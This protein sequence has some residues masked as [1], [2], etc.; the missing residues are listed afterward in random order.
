MG[1][2]L[3]GPT[4]AANEAAQM[5]S[6]AVSFGTLQL[7][8]GGQLI[9]LMADHQATGGY[10]RVAHIITAHL[11]LLAQMNPHQFFTFTFVDTESAEQILLAQH[12]H[13]LSIQYA[14]AFNIQKIFS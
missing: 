1:Y 13:L 3:D 2:R 8:P 7:L 14:A 12:R 11:P 5:L 6:S 4:L 9:L 10:P